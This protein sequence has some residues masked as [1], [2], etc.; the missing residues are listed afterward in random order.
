MEKWK[1]EAGRERRVLRL[2][3]PAAPWGANAACS[4]KGNREARV[5]QTSR[6][7]SFWPTPTWRLH[8]SSINSWLQAASTSAHS[9]AQLSVTPWTTA[10]R[11]LCPWNSSGAKPR[12]G[13]LDL[14]Q[15]IFSTQESNPCLLPLLQWQGIVH[16]WATRETLSG[17]ERLLWHHWLCGCRMGLGCEGASGRSFPCGPGAKTLCSKCRGSGFDPWSGNKM[18]QLSL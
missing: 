15:G 16:H 5:S 8:G 18:P 13:C 17:G 2:C 10:A 6:R 12:V 4:P 11:L 9:R 3:D 1:R 7:P 14:L